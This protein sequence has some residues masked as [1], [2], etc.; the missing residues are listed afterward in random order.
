MQLDYHLVDLQIS[1]LWGPRYRLILL[2]FL[3]E[4]SSTGFVRSLLFFLSTDYDLSIVQPLPPAA[5][6]CLKMEGIANGRI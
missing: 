6:V 3:W 1:D 2:L 4:N 5:K